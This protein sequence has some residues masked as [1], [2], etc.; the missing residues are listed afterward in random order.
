MTIDWHNR[1]QS[2]WFMAHQRARKS[3]A[4]RAYVELMNNQHRSAAELA[5]INWEKRR[6][7]LVY[8]FKTIPF[9]QSRFQGLG[10]Q[11]QDFAD[12]GVW[13]SIPILTRKDVADHFDEIRA[14]GWPERDCYMSTTGG[15]TGN[16]LKVLHDATF[17]QAALNWRMTRWWGVSPGGDL[18]RIGRFTMEEANAK[19]GKD[20]KGKKIRKGAP[21][22]VVRLSASQLDD[23]MIRAFIGEWN[24]VRPPLLAGYVGSIQ[25]VAVHIRRHGLRVH[26]PTAIQV[27]SAP[28]SSVVRAV[29]EEAFQAPVYDQYG[30]CEVFWLAAECR[31]R[32]GLHIFADAR[33]LEFVDGDGRCR[34]PDVYGR[35]LVTDLENRAFPL[36]RYENG[37]TG[38]LLS[39]S[40]DCGVNLPLMDSV[41]GRMSDNV[42]LRGGA[43]VSG[44]YLTTIFD[45]CPDAVSAFQVRQHADYAIDILVVPNIGHPGL[46]DDLRSVQAKLAEKV[47]GQAPVRIVRVSEIA[48]SRG[49]TKYVISDVPD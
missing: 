5:A 20:G 2:W 14:P 47:C 13:N 46:E 17:G 42:K 16:P 36:I 31:R 18:G 45:G 10:L 25:H 6:R 44:V 23:E 4:Y 26:K 15:T 40:C 30:S 8:A 43:A 27:T 49:K 12:P 1:F 9:Y 32:Q 33:H 39:R 21:I 41:V 38:R 28:L 24:A 37:D 34:A 22:R 35:T 48:A 11:E 19:P 3:P 7:L 29:I